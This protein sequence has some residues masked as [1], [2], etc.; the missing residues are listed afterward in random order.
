M[1]Y[2]Y[3]YPAVCIIEYSIILFPLERL[4]LLEIWI[5][6]NENRLVRICY[7]FNGFAGN[8]IYQLLT[9]SLVNSLKAQS[10]SVVRS[11]QV[12]GLLMHMVIK[13]PSHFFASLIPHPLCKQ[14]KVI[15]Q[16]LRVEIA[17]VRIRGTLYLNMRK[18]WAIILFITFTTSCLISRLIAF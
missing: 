9:E 2:N 11:Q 13:L 1:N 18:A 7:D 14:Q 5:S 8:N 12:N 16:I 10:T 15:S 3:Y 6:C 17:L 4:S